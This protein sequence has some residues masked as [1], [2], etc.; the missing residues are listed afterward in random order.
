[1][2]VKSLVPASGKECPQGTM[3]ITYASGSDG[4]DDWALF[5]RGD[6]QRITVVY[7]HGSYSCA[8]QIFTRTDVRDF[9][10]SRIIADRHPLLSANMRG[11]SYMSPAATADSNSE[12][13][14]CPTN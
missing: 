6:K 1:M 11:T 7:L 13:T 10:L 12:R 3:R 14:D 2:I 8:D 9:W 4:A 5:L